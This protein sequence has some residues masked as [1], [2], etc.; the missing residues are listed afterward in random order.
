MVNDDNYINDLKDRL[1]QRMK[2][3]AIS[4][5]VIAKEIGITLVTLATFLNTK[6]VPS[7]ITAAKIENWLDK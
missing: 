5:A 7:H 3:R 4:K 6:R 2:K 1:W